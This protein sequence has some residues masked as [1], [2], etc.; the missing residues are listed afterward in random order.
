MPD[1]S[2]E[3]TPR[4]RP[5]RQLWR[6]ETKSWLEL[7]DK[8]AAWGFDARDEQVKSVARAHPQ[9]TG[10]TGTPD[11]MNAALPTCTQAFGSFFQAI[12][13]DKSGTVEEDEIRTL[14]S[15]T[16][17]TITSTQMRR[18]FASIGLAVDAK[19]TK[20]DFVKLMRQHGVS[21]MG[22][23]FS[24]GEGRNGIFDSNTRLMMLT[25]RRQQL[26]RDFVDPD[27][28]THF[29]NVEVFSQAYGGDLPQPTRAVTSVPPSPRVSQH[30]RRLFG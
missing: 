2:G 21:L 15:I 3:R 25:Y 14:I 1:S 8:G 19:L 10:R 27:K 22:S 24:G 7:R 6:T 17:R 18:M 29:A 16:G 30:A 23:H 13:I 28:R 26:L 5:R 20:S 4:G 9:P 12:D 11:R